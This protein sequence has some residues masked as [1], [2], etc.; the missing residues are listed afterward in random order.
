MTKIIMQA[1]KQMFSQVGDQKKTER[2]AGR[3]ESK[4]AVA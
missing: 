2:F 4:Q 1:D 3:H